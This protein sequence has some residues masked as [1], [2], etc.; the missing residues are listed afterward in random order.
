MKES[1]TPNSCNKSPIAYHTN[2]CYI[3]KQE[4]HREE[5]ENGPRWT[6]GALI[7][8]GKQSI[9]AEGTVRAKTRGGKGHSMYW[10][11]WCWGTGC[12]VEAHLPIVKPWGSHFLDPNPPKSPQYQSN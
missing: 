9:L 4:V 10:A 3:I 11:E 5:S 6:S 2:K 12:A 1:S 7:D 8:N